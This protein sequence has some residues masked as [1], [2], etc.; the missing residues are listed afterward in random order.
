MHNP[1]QINVG[2][3]DSLNANK[4]I[5]QNIIVVSEHDKEKKLMELLDEVFDL[6]LSRIEFLLNF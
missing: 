5:T 2:D 3:N 6:P 4:N 1:I